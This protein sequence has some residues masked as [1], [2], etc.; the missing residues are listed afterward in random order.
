[1]RRMAANARLCASGLGHSGGSL[2]PVPQREL[3]HLPAQYFA[4]CLIR[5]RGTAIVEPT[6]QEYDLTSG[7]G[8]RVSE[9]RRARA[10]G[11][12]AADAPRPSLVREDRRALDRK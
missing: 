7:E 8:L 5:G 4:G 3:V 12:T 9:E 1:M 2:S 6:T 10:A 11:P